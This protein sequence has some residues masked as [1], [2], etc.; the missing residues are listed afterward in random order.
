MTFCCSFCVIRF[1]MYLYAFTCFD[2]VGQLI[3]QKFVISSSVQPLLHEAVQF[4]HHTL[5]VCVLVLLDTTQNIKTMETTC[6]LWHI[7]IYT[8]H[9]KGRYFFL[10]EGKNII[11]L[12]LTKIFSSTTRWHSLSLLCFSLEIPSGCRVGHKTHSSDWS[13]DKPGCRASALKL[14]LCKKTN[15][16]PFFTRPK[17][18]LFLRLQRGWGQDS[19]EKALE[20]VPDGTLSALP[21]PVCADVWMTHWGVEGTS[22]IFLCH[23][24]ILQRWTDVTGKRYEFRCGTGGEFFFQFLYG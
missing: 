18:C 3:E 8:F 1:S 10:T 16:R 9:R 21:H 23:K 11:F 4:I 19:R 22:F 12:P 7:L 17:R 14:S 20:S 15:L 13:P 24:F 6:T 5:H 2:Y